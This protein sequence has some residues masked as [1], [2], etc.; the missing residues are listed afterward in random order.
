MVRAQRQPNIREA[1]ELLAAR[2]DVLPELKGAVRP[3]VPARDT[4]DGYAAARYSFG[5]GVKKQS[6]PL[7]FAKSQTL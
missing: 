5:S 3:G 2:Q 4:D 1:A 6:A 7:P